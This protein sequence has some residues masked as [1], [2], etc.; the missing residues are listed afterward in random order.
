MAARKPMD[1]EERKILADFALKQVVEYQTVRRHVDTL[2]LSGLGGATAMLGLLLPFAFGQIDRLEWRLLACGLALFLVSNFLLAA[3]MALEFREVNARVAARA[4]LRK[5]RDALDEDFFIDIVETPLLSDGDV[6]AGV[7]TALLL[8]DEKFE[9]ANVIMNAVS[10]L[11]VA[12]VA[13]GVSGVAYALWG[14]I[15]SAAG[16]G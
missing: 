13:T 2:R 1:S 15:G 4:A 8:K 16:R 6:E 10:F 12:A 9:T 3:S 7:R 11:R 14:F 5:M